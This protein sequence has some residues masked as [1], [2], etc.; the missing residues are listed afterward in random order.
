MCIRDRSYTAG[1]PE[2]SGTA[3][4]IDSGCS[5]SEED[6]S[7]DPT[8]KSQEPPKLWRLAVIECRRSRPLQR[9]CWCDG[10]SLLEPRMLV[11]TIAR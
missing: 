6:S 10:F 11:G 2:A 8:L 7:H 4:T 5:S 9:N 1:S 3:A